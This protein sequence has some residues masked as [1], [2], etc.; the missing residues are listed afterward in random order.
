[1]DGGGTCSVHT[2]INIYIYTYSY[3][4]HIQLRLRV[5]MYKNYVA[6]PGCLIID[7]HREL[8]ANRGPLLFETVFFLF[9]IDSILKFPRPF[10]NSSISVFPFLE[11]FPMYIYIYGHISPA[12][13]LFSID[14]Y[15]AA[16]RRFH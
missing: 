16:L 7:V 15:S 2:C 14:N 13:F 8:C 1:M 9:K 12:L 10:T 4:I 3:R 6:P 11:S 5:Y